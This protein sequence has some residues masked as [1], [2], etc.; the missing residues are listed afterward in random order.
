MRHLM[1]DFNTSLI[2]A[3]YLGEHNATELVIVKPVDVIGAM[4]SVAFMT[5]GEVIHS[6]FFGADE[7][8]RVPLWQQL[9]QDYELGVQLEAYDEKG[10]YLGKS[11]MITLLFGNS[12][13]GTDVI[14]DAENPDVYSEI[15]QNTAFR[16]V[17]EDNVDTLDKL[18]MSEDGT[19]NFNGEPVFT[20]KYYVFF[21]NFLA[22]NSE[23]TV[24]VYNGTYT[25]ENVQPRVNDFVV[26]DGK[27][28]QITEIKE[29]GF[30]AKYLFDLS[31]TV[32]L[33]NYVTVEN[34]GSLTDLETQN[35]NS[36]VE[37][38][39]EINFKLNKATDDVSTELSELE[40]K[41]DNIAV[42]RP[43]QTI[44]LLSDGSSSQ[45]F[46]VD[47]PAPNYFAI[48]DAW[49][50]L[51]D[52]DVVVGAEI[53]KIELKVFE[54]GEWNDIHD[55]Y[56]VDGVPYYVSASKIHKN[57]YGYIRFAIAS[58]L[59]LGNY[60]YNSINNFEPIYIR[61]TYYAD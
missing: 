34:F 16:E 26:G 37:A 12:A 29:Y 40:N 15:A 19:L 59:V 30:F 9:T 45:F 38:V 11:A 22:D 39:N 2:E 21:T 58:P 25:P 46:T 6:K 52:E 5:N 31:Q 3:G 51:T 36:M 56:T 24:I 28:Y 43:T 60:I 35:K 14:A 7:D 27:L 4:Y 18:A 23:N 32:N 41:I 57:T 42:E 13:H 50:T 61:I 17:L 10:D 49:A 55:M 48:E 33:N 20:S 53:K 1:I 47:D 44:E 8:I 54:D